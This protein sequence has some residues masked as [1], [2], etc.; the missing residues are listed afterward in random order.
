MRYDACSVSAAAALYWTGA[1]GTM[2]RPIAATCMILV[3]AA[4]AWSTAVAELPPSVRGAGHT[5][6]QVGQGRLTWLGFGIYRASLWSGDGRYD[7]LQPGQPVALALWYERKFSRQQLLDITVGEWERLGIAPAPVRE[8]WAHELDAI[9]LD[10]QPGD[11][12][13]ALVMPGEAT[14]FYDR[15]R[16]LGQVTDPAFGQAFLSIWLDSRS[17]VRDLR[18]QLLGGTD[19]T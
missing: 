6:S 3:A 5:L 1:G 15:D 16:L 19:R 9:W 10:V 13:T 8:A 18:A 2:R 11:N 17:A 12:M 14:L 4:L 7:G